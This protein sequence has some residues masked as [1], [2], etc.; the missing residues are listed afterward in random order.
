MKKALPKVIFGTSSLGNL[1]SAPPFETKLNIV[2]EIVNANPELAVFDSAGKYGAGL[3]LESL[4]ECLSELKIPKDKV[5]ISNKLA[6][7]RVPLTSDEP[8]F[9]PGAWVDLKNDAIQDIS[10]QG[11]IDCYEQ[12]NELLGDYDAQLVSIHD[13]D[14][15]LASAKNDEDLKD[16]KEKLLEA[17]RALDELKK[18]GRVQSVGVG[19]KD[20]SVIDFISDHFQLDW[21]MFAC[22]ITPYTHSDFAIKLLKKLGQQGVDVIN[23][24]VFNAGFL[25]GGTH[26]DYQLISQETHP[27][28][29]EWRD[30]FF[31]I[32]QEFDIKPAAACV[33]FSFLFPEIK[34]IALNT[35]KPERVK[36]NM[37]LAHAKIPQGF[38]DKMKSEKLI[39]I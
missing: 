20:I 8:T 15:Y 13:P 25:I 33:Q 10:Y 2:K 30:K 19:A 16:R 21:A 12:G 38:W 39:N 37:D 9:E 23:S 4:A 1:Y 11:I 3:A 32:C 26:F 36:S 29:F 6:W 18:S 24:A 5:L 17:F 27:E 22:S 34:A 7:K 35:S 28:V 14:E 31:A